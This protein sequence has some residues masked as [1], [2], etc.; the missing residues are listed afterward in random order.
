MLL[1]ATMV[2]TCKRLERIHSAQRLKFQKP[3]ESQPTPQQELNRDE[4]YFFV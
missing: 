4:M 1:I 3:L 2:Q